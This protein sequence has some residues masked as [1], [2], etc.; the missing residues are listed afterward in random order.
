[1]YKSYGSKLAACPRRLQSESFSITREEEQEGR[2][3]WE[4]TT[5]VRTI[6]LCTHS[7]LITGPPITAVLTDAFLP[8]VL[9]SRSHALSLCYELEGAFCQLL[10]EEG[11]IK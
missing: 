10:S 5:T 7:Q 9:V 3:V 11:G 4:S 8:P 2:E 6:V 1:M